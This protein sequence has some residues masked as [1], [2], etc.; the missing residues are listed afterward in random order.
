MTLTYMQLNGYIYANNPPFEMCVDDNVIW[1][2]YSMGTEAHSYHLHGDNIYNPTTKTWTATIPMDPGQMLTTL[3]SA[4][5]PGWWYL[6]CHFNDHLSEGMEANY[7]VYGGPY[8]ECPLEPLE[9]GYS[10]DD[11]DDENDDDDDDN[12]YD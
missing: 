1:Y 9:K 7:I 11:E 12:D 8:G 6:I 10:D 5:N 3:M 2:L 4:S